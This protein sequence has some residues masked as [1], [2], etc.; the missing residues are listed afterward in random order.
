MRLF[1]NIL[2]RLISFLGGYSFA[3]P[4]DKI[5]HILGGRNRTLEQYPACAPFFSGELLRQDVPVRA[6]ITT[7]NIIELI[8]AYNLGYG[9]SAYLSLLIH[10]FGVELYVSAEKSW[11]VSRT[12]LSNSGFEHKLRLASREG[13]KSQK[14]FSQ[15]QA[16]SARKAPEVSQMR[17]EKKKQ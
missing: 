9:M 12:D 15:L 5:D 3:Q 10:A 4:C 8:S 1:I 13:H 6:D 16:N 14:I 11:Y 2:P 17:N 7:G